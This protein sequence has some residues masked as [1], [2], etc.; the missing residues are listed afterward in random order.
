MLPNLSMASVNLQ[1]FS[2][3]VWDV[4]TNEFYYRTS[5]TKANKMRDHRVRFGW[6]SDLDS[7]L[8]FWMEKNATFDLFMATELL[9][10]VE[11]ETIS[12]IQVAAV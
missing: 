11:P 10:T 1:K 3:N 8:N 12:K 9:S 7:A 6:N 2:C 5:L 4:E